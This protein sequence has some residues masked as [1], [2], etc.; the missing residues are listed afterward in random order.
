MRS[1]PASPRQKF[2]RASQRR[3]W[4]RTADP[5]RPRAMG[6]SILPLGCQIGIDSPTRGSVSYNYEDVWCLS[7]SQIAPSCGRRASS[8]SRRARA[9]DGG[10]SGSS[11]DSALKSELVCLR[12]LKNQAK[13]AKGDGSRG[14]PPGGAVTFGKVSPVYGLDGGLSDRA[15][16]VGRVSAQSLCQVGP[17]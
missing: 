3:K 1:S 2:P 7:D 16:C 17:A 10:V 4:A 9:H 15:V 5:S 14:A 12:Q 13:A 11:A 8:H 6:V